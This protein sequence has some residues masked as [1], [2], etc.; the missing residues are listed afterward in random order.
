VAPQPFNEAAARLLLAL[1]PTDSDHFIKWVQGQSTTTKK[2]VTFKGRP[3]LAA[4]G[5]HVTANSFRG[6]GALGVKPWLNPTAEQPTTKF[7]ALDLDDLD[8]QQLRDSP[9][10]NTLEGRGLHPYITKGSTGR[11]LHV[12]FFF[13]EAIPVETVFLALVALKEMLLA[14]IT[15]EPRVELF[16]S[17]KTSGGK[18]IYLPYRG[19]ELDG[20]GANPLLDIEAGFQPVAL[21]ETQARLRYTPTE[22]IVDL[23]GDCRPS[24]TFVGS[25]QR[26]QLE[27]D[28]AHMLFK[29]EAERLEQFWRP[30]VR[31]YLVKGFTA[32][33]VSGLKIGEQKIVQAVTE[34]HVVSES[35]SDRGEF[36]LNRL[37]EAARRT[38]SRHSNGGLVAWHHYY[39]QA[40]VAL[41]PPL[42]TSPEQLLKLQFLTERLNC[43]AFP[44]RTAL[45][46]KAMY[47]TLIRLAH[48]FGRVEPN[49]IAVQVAR[50][51][52]AM[53]AN[54]GDKG[55]KASLARLRNYGLVATRCSNIAGEA[56]T[57]VLLLPGLDSNQDPQSVPINNRRA[58]QDWD[59]MFEHVAFRR[60][61][62]GP[63]S[64]LIVQALH[65]GGSLGLTR[66]Q[67]AAVLSMYPYRFRKQLDL[68]THYKVIGAGP[69]DTYSLTENWRT[70]LDKAAEARGVHRVRES[71]EQR[72]QAERV[73]H[74]AFL[75]SRGLLGGHSTTA[76][77]S[78]PSSPNSEPLGMSEYT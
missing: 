3:G 6:P 54:M 16:P 20:L 48:E 4:Y 53:K 2:T 56:G 15:P 31:N 57:I 18:A 55:S 63:I 26:T 69:G 61:A 60:R 67:L 34:L 14:S 11:G 62:L 51:S 76:A 71:Q 72:H 13:R 32:Y 75:S 64:M 29:A 24:A 43:F 41:P 58:V 52:L 59:P 73:A 39:E 42:R 8:D 38:I 10:L 46:D 40:D 77:V 45:A 65:Q 47:S 21:A 33:A 17:S 1:F 23:A 49:G 9:F 30:G 36:E 7:M 12:Y 70:R 44:G 28:D 35:T 74:S 19:A 78:A 50:R 68:L 5:R 66:S 27:A 22:C 25:K 37:L